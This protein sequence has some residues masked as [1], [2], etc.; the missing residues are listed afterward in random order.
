MGVVQNRPMR[1]PG[2]AKAAWSEAMARS[3]VATN[4]HPAAVAIPC[5]SAITGC[6]MAWIFIISSLHTSNRRRYSL[7]SRP[8]ISERSWPEQKTLPAAA[9]ITA[10]T[11]RSRP[12][13]SRQSISSS[14]SSSDSALRRCG[15]FN[16]TT[17]QGRVVLH[18]DALIAHDG[19]HSLISLLSTRVRPPEGPCRVAEGIRHEMTI[20]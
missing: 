7:M 13:A 14:I 11:V 12:M 1:T 8:T 17:A 15:R 16:V 9:R 18:G 6:G 3:Q 5:T 20:V 2:V 10:R 19:L 4:W